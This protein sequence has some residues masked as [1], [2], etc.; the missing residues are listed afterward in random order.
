MILT[1]LL[2]VLLALVAGFIGALFGLGGG[3]I[4]VPGLTLL[5]QKDVKVAVAA[6]L[7]SVIATSSAAATVYVAARFTNIRL[8]MLLEV[9]TTTGALLGAFLAVHVPGRY[10]F[11]AFAGVLVYAAVSMLRSRSASAEPTTVAAPARSLSGSYC[12]PAAGTNISYVVTHVPAGMLG[13]LGAGVV[14]ALLG[15]GGGIIKVPLMNAVMGI[16]LKA[17]IGTSNFTIGVTAATGAIVFWA[18]GHID[19][20]VAAPTAIG[21]LIGAR[22]GTR[23]TGRARSRALSLAF[24]VLVAVTAVQMFLRGFGIRI[25]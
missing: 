3:I 5:F 16:P 24:V 10:L 4:L 1:F 8:G 7:I 13:S 23:V 20:Y 11:F 17:A 21:V 6:S 18:N 19:P 15:I 22:I 14:S 25:G 2:L 12:D 9:A